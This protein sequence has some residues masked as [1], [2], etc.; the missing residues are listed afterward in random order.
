M[1]RPSQLFTADDRQR[2][3]Q[4][5]AGAESQT[6]A[7]IVAAAAGVSGRY[8]RS[9]DIV[10][11]WTGAIALAAVWLLW[12][13]QIPERGSWGEAPAWLELAAILLAVVL[14]FVVGAVVGSR[15]GWLR[16]LFTPRRQ[17]R[18]EVWSRAKQTF[19]DR[20]VYRTTGSSGVLIFVSLYERMAA[21]VADQTVLEKLGQPALDEICAHLTAQLTGRDPTAAICSTIEVIGQ[22]SRPACPAPLATRTNST[23]RW[24]CLIE[25]D[26]R[27]GWARKRFQEP[28]FRCNWLLKMGQAGRNISEQSRT[29]GAAASRSQ[30]STGC[31][32]IHPVADMAEFALALR[33]LPTR[34]GGIDWGA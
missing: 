1:K 3:N 26:G 27:R 16:H 28:L 31:Q 7:E 17:M 9:E 6:S 20:R 19:C 21:I 8:D 23:M 29:Q 2:V 10:G 32:R 24:C 18:E 15:I 22:R 30:I 14:G 5:V 12:P 13:R 4:A 25:C 11:L 34:R 33:V